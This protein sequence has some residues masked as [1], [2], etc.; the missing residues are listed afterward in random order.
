MTDST[1]PSDA[2]RLGSLTVVPSLNRLV[3]EDG[4]TDVE[5][6]VMRVLAVL[7]DTPGEVVTRRMSS[8]QSGRTRW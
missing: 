2:F 8:T 7:A 3:R 5:P 4:V 1:L 6:R